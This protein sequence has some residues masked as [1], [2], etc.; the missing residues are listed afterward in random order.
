M[1]IAYGEFDTEILNLLTRN[2][3]D[4]LHEQGACVKKGNLAS[5]P[6]GVRVPPVLPRRV[7]DVKGGMIRLHESYE[8]E[9][10]DYVTLSHRWGNK[11]SFQTTLNTL[12]SHLSSIDFGDLPESF[13]D[14]IIVTRNLGVRFLWIDAICIVQND[15]ND[16]SKQSPLMGMIYQ[17]SYCTIAAHSARNSKVGFLECKSS[18]HTVKTLNDTNS[19]LYLG[20]PPIFKEVIDYSYIKR[21]A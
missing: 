11:I 12:K 7:L 16:W 14:A 17:N 21:R 13:Q 15:Q 19:A 2:A 10:A 18:I 8:D 3:R 20:V 4:C 9:R 5:S 1:P 6:S